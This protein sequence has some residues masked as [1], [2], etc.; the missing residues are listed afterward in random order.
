MLVEQL[1]LQSSVVRFADADPRSDRLLFDCS[2]L[3]LPPTLVRNTQR[4]QGSFL[5][6]VFAAL[7][8]SGVNVT[9]ILGASGVSDRYRTRPRL[10]TSAI[11]VRFSSE[12]AAC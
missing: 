3:K 12:V 5:G 10:S 6:S 4:F 11:P 1:S 9:L 8:S 7:V 2:P